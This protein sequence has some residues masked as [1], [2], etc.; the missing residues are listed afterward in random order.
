LENGGGLDE[1]PTRMVEEEHDD[2]TAWSNTVPENQR[3]GRDAA[4][5][6]RR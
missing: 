1:Q 6:E 4:I 3:K 2:K 5:L